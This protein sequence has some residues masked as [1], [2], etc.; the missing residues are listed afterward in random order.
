M[1]I[2]Q[3]CWIRTNGFLLPKQDLYQTELSPEK[4]NTLASGVLYHTFSDLS[5][6]IFNF[7]FIS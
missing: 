6:F 3:D 1:L 4:A 2:G 5:S 7:F